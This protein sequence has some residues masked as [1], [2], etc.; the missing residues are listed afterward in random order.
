[1]KSINI[2]YNSEEDVQP[3]F[4]QV[5]EKDKQGNLIKADI[6]DDQLYM[7]KIG[8]LSIAELLSYVCE[9][10]LEDENYK[11]TIIKDGQIITEKQSE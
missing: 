11:T 8:A 9:V 4:F 3:I 1:M 5:N 10:E 2:G 7:S 6:I